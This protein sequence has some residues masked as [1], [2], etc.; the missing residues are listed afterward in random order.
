MKELKLTIPNTNEHFSWINFIRN[1]KTLDYSEIDKVTLDFNQC[2]FLNTGSLTILACLIEEIRKQK[3]V[4][5][6]Y[7]NG[8][9]KLNNHLNNIRFKEY[10]NTGFDRDAYTN[11]KNTTTLCLW[12]ISSNMIESYGQQA[13]LFYKRQ[14]FQHLDLQPF[15]STLVEIFNNIFNHS[16]SAVDGY[17][18]TQYFPN[19][20]KMSFSVCDFG[21]GIATSINNYRLNEN[22]EPYSPDSFAIQKTLEAG[23]SSKSIPQNAGLGLRNVLDFSENT[24][25][26]ISILS[27][28]G[29]YTKKKQRKSYIKR[30]KIYL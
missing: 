19:L 5:F 6:S 2:T 9:T 16:K 21:E 26:T 8:S 12:H 28:N 29:Y 24:S 13:Q 4:F 10:W 14:F 11:S 22:K 25:G 18:L 1:A 7:I 3:N 15:S 27:N 17:V 20:H 30:I 23:I